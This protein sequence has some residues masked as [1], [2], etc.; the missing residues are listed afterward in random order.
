M[1]PLRSR[2]AWDPE[3]SKGLRSSALFQ[4]PEPLAGRLAGHSE[5]DGD[6]IPRSA[7]RP[8]GLH[9][10]SEPSLVCSRGLRRGGDRLEVF[11]VVRLG[12][13]RVE[14][15]GELLKALCRSLNL[16]VC[17]SHD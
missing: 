13:R 2:R 6:V 14:L 17:V 5:G 9:S 12:G 4:H 16:V 3:L 11:D 1:G 7:V 8:G 10:F 15:V